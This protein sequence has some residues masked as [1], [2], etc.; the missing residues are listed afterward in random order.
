MQ[1]QPE[2]S[3]GSGLPTSMAPHVFGWQNAIP[4]WA[5]ASK[6]S[7]V[8][9]IHYIPY[10]SCLTYSISRKGRQ[11]K[12]NTKNGTVISLSNPEPEDQSK[13]PQTTYDS[14]A[15]SSRTNDERSTQGYLPRGGAC[16]SCRRRKMVSPNYNHWRCYWHRCNQKCDGKR[17][18]CTQCDRAGRA[19]DCEYTIGQE[20]STVQ[21]LE[22]NISRLEARIQELQNPGASDT[23][24]AAVRLHQ[25]YTVSASASA[26][27][28]DE[29]SYSFAESPQI[30]QDPPR[31]IAEAL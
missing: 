19:E 17:P 22:E 6:Q 21:I 10:F 18:V 7:K 11:F 1:H 16:V 4:P 14:M 27:R 9:V 29:T 30:I 20:R 12:R 3:I 25:P 24:T 28:V 26:P 15:S 23:A 13:R 31:H 8:F 5:N 2:T